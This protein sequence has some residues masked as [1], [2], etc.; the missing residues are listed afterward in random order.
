[1]NRRGKWL[2]RRRPSG[3]HAMTIGKVKWFNDEKGYGF[4]TPEGGGQDIFCHYSSIRMEGFRTLQEGQKV[5][6]ELIEGA[7][8]PAAKDVQSATG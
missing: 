6:F 5:S 8:G 7:K 3:V 4:I 2:S 1:V